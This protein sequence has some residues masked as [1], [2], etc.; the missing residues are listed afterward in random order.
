MAPTRM[1]GR[2]ARQGWSFRLP[3]QGKLSRRH[4]QTAVDETRLDFCDPF[5]SAFV[6][7]Y[8]YLGKETLRR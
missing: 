1:P 4:K 2:S 6:Q 8:V 5:K 3:L 7:G